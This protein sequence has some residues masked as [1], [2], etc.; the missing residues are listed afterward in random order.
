MGYVPKE[1]V[2]RVD[3]TGTDL[4]GLDITLKR[5]SVDAIKEVARLMTR[6][7]SGRKS[8]GGDTAFLDD[9]VEAF[10][11]IIQR[12]NVVDDAGNPVAPTPGNISA[13][14][15]FHEFTLPAFEACSKHLS[16]VSDDLGKGSPST[17][18]SV[19]AVFDLPMEVL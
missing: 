8:D 5:M 2:R 6:A 14:Y 7:E 9:V 19:P 17:P 3:F 18:P 13:G 4:E 11:G 15:D 12:W 10:A 16:G 1:V